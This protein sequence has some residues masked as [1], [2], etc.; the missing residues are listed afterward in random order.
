M[1]EPPEPRDKRA[2]FNP[3]LVIALAHAVLSGQRPKPGDILTAA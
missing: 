2:Q 1:S 3:E